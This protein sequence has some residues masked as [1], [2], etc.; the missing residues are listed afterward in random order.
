MKKHNPRRFLCLLIFS[1]VLIF[2]PNVSIVD[3]LPDF[4]GYF[5]LASLFLKA[6]DSAPFF[7]EARVAFTRLGWL[8]LAK[9]PALLLIVYIRRGNTL[10]N[11]VFALVSFVF[12]VCEFILIISAVK[13]IFSA[14]SYLGQR[15]DA[16]SLITP[17]GK[18]TEGNA[19]YLDRL[20]IFTVIFFGVKC[21]LYTIPDMF[22][23]TRTADTAA[24]LQ[25][26]SGSKYYP[27]AII[28][29]FIVTATV[30]TIWLCRIIKYVKAVHREGK[31][32][33]ALNSLRRTDASEKFEA[34]VKVRSIS[35]ALS[36][37]IISSVLSFDLTFDNFKEINIL[38]HFIYGIALL[39][40]IYSIT[41]HTESAKKSK[42]VLA[43]YI[44]GAIFTL[45]AV[46][47]FITSVGFLTEY[48]YLELVSN[49]NAR[50][51]YI[52]VIITATV[53]HFALCAF[54]ILSAFVLRKFIYE[55]TGMSPDSDRYRRTEKEYHSA[56]IKRCFF[57]FITGV[58]VGQ[59]KLINTV[60][61]G[62]AEYIF[63]TE[64][65]ISASAVP[66][67]NLLVSAASIFFIG[68]TLYYTSTLK[69]EVRMKYE[70]L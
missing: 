43:T 19:G 27:I 18:D 17:F 39:F 47:A 30:G 34:K 68:Y 69:E 53:E 40:A 13:N 56:L 62:K 36:F 32:D 20:R 24:G 42:V 22:L 12:A 66:W 3:V 9:F 10:D 45:A 4:I 2:N 49:P 16:Q 51:A 8:N 14:I 26:V 46:A 57:M 48:G 60:F 25:L 6:A 31:F 35:N 58:F 67:F 59:L 29:A 64:G 7:E 23:L 55:H 44:V 15:T 37:L 33:S 61:N 41:K 70:N 5:I 1:L 50:H 54:L 38:P 11:D 63:S 52:P 28:V 21:T 65:V